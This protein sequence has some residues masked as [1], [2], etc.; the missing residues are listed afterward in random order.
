MNYNRDVGAE[1]LTEDQAN[2]I[3]KQFLDSRGYTNMKQTYYL[4]ESGIVTINYA[5][6][7]NEITGNG[8]YAGS[9]IKVP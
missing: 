9:R 4:K 2:E 3:G 8:H 7:Q 1:V 5:Y 6:S